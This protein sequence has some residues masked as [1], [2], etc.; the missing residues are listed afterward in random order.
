MLVVALAR[1]AELMR[2]LAV[3]PGSLFIHITQGSDFQA[4]FLINP[5]FQHPDRSFIRPSEKK[6]SPSKEMLPPSGMIK[7]DSEIQFV[8]SFR[9]SASDVEQVSLSWRLSRCLGPSRTEKERDTG[10][11]QFVWNCLKRL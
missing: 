9:L 4:H 11:C 5:S 10:T 2:L 1:V 8:S 6:N 7:K 3:W